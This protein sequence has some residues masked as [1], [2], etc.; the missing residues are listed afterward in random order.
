MATESLILHPYDWKV[1]DEYDDRGNLVIHAWCL[2]RESKP[3]LVRFHDFPAYCHVELP[4]FVGHRRINWSGYKAQ[5]VY[6]TICWKL[7]S[8]KPFKYFYGQKEKLYYYRAGRRYPM[9]TLLFDTVSKMKKCKWKLDKAF[10]VRN[11]GVVACKVWETNIP[12]VRKLLTLRNMKYSQWFTVNAIKV[13]KEEK[14]SKLEN[15]YV[16]DR[17]TLN[18]IP[19]EQTNG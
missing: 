16:A 14:V 3:H 2:D 1:K 12:I 9:L 5:Q 19:P 13:T 10:K 6:E 17:Y 4:L 18:P 7:G 8:N 11:F 15:E